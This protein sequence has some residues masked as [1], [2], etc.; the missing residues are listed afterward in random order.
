M[1]LCQDGFSTVQT[2]EEGWQP[3]QRLLLRSAN[4]DHVFIVGKLACRSVLS[5]AHKSSCVSGLF[6]DRCA[7]S[8]YIG[9]AHARQESHFHARSHLQHAIVAGFSKIA[10]LEDDLSFLNRTFSETL[11]D[12][13]PSLLQS[14]LGTCYG[15]IRPFFLQNRFDVRCSSAC[16]CTGSNYF[17][18]NFVS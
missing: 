14:M 11:R 5:L 10:V 6:V 3:C 16:R 2:L 15:R 13:I 18:E 8:H 17:G 12:D 4:V 9:V 1:P 7:P